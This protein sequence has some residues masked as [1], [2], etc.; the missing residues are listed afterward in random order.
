MK[1]FITIFLFFTLTHSLFAQNVSIDCDTIGAYI[2]VDG[3]K[4]AKIKSKITHVNIDK[5]EHEI[6]IIHKLDGLWQGIEIQNTKISTSYKQLLFNNFSIEKA[7]KL[8]KFAKRFSKNAT[9]VH[10]N[11]FNRDWQDD[12]A[13]RIR[14]KSWQ[15]AIAYCENLSM[16]GYNDWRLPNNDTIVNILEYS[17]TDSKLSKVFTHLNEGFYWS[18]SEDKKNKNN[19]YRIYLNEGCSDMLPKDNLFRVLCVRGK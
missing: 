8:K 16:G 3:I 6:K 15:E 1:Y 13:I 17:N 2:Y 12:E 14:Q 5:G 7:K 4:R 9:I 10:D 18:R 11:Q 19:A